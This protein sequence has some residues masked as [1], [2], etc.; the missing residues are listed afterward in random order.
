MIKVI[1]LKHEALLLAMDYFPYPGER[2]FLGFM[3]ANH[4]SLFPKLLDQ[5]QFYRRARRLE[6]L[7]DTIGSSRWGLISSE[8]CS[9]IRNQYP[10]S[11]TS[12]VKVKA[13]LRAVLPTVIVRVAR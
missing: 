4:L 8:P 1:T 13:T 10:S 6:G 11:V 3:R 2:Q 9:S 12:E 5:S 7:M